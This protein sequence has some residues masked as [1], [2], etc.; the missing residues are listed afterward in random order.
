MTDAESPS[1]TSPR[2]RT[3]SS[4]SLPGILR[5]PSVELADNDPPTSPSPMDYYSDDDSD[6]DELIHPNN[7]TPMRKQDGTFDL[8][9]SM[10][11]RRGGLGRNAENKW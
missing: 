2:A 6:N 7:S 10:W 5:K 11:K 8:C 9:E 1:N 4:N 3:T